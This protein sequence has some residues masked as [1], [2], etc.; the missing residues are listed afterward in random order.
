MPEQKSK[1]EILSV[2]KQAGMRLTRQRLAIIEY[3]AGRKD[4]PGARQIFYEIKASSDIS[5]AT[6]YNTLK[7]LVDLEL[8]KEI[9]FEHAENRYD[10]N[11]E[12]H[13]NLVCA[14][15]GKIEDVDV[16]LPLSPEEIKTRKN[17]TT[18]NYRLEF[19]GICAVCQKN[20]DK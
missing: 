12:P 6:I 16:I 1:N 5:F 17:F 15:C 18:T 9:D 3:V 19:I 7:T 4:H 2:L 8:I 10:T 14:R 13:L 11:L 20:K